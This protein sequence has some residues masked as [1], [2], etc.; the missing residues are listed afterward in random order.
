MK[1][2]LYLAAMSL[3]V[4]LTAC[5]STQTS[6]PEAGMTTPMTAPVAPA[7][8]A[9][10]PAPAAP[11]VPAAVAAP[12]AASSSADEIIIDN[13]DPSFKS[14]GSWTS[15]AGGNDFKDGSAYASGTLNTDPANTATW[16]PDIKNAGAYDVYEWHGDDPNSDHATKAPFTVKSDDGE[17]TILVNLQTNSGKWNLLGTFNFAAGNGGNVSLNSNGADGNVLADA[18]KFVPHH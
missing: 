10:M 15:G 9:A 13:G 2:K 17:K 1:L 6:K 18:V 3:S 16:T 4:L 5:Q 12:V 8:P 11:A 14:E 7:E